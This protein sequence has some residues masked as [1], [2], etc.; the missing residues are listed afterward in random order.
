MGRLVCPAA[1]PQPR[2]D[3]GARLAVAVLLCVVSPAAANGLSR[4]ENDGVEK[5][6]SIAFAIAM[7]ALLLAFCVFIVVIVPR[8]FSVAPRTAVAEQRLRRKDKKGVTS[9]EILERLPPAKTPRNSDVDGQPN[10][11]VCLCEVEVD[12]E[13]ITTQCGHTFHKDCVLQWWTHKP[14]SS[15][16][17]PTCR[18]KQKLRVKSRDGRRHSSRAHREAHSEGSGDES[19]RAPT[20]P[21]AARQDS[22]LPDLEAGRRAGPTAELP[23]RSPHSAAPT[24]FT[25]VSVADEATPMAQVIALPLS[26]SL[27]VTGDAEVVECV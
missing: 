18:T 6:E 21:A 2:M 14:R 13:S 22:W 8:R 17:C 9:E 5:D 7:M 12:E 3:T 10:C 11:T 19:G 26:Q 1:R 15:I 16:R 24:D 23:V 25:H 4:L 27:P 20:Q